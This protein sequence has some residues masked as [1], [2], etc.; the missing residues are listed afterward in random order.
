MDAVSR[1]SN[2]RKSVWGEATV[3]LD[4]VVFSFLGMGAGFTE[5][6]AA[7]VVGGQAG[8]LEDSEAGAPGNGFLTIGA[9]EIG[10]EADSVAR[11]GGFTLSIAFAP[12]GA[13]CCGLKGAKEGEGEG[14]VTR[15]PNPTATK[16]MSSRNQV[17]ELTAASGRPFRVLPS[18]NLSLPG[19]CMSLRRGRIHLRL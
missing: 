17:K 12:M 4:A 1:F 6:L 16:K 2:V 8:S 7:D 5:V 14:G 3:G 9:G 18:Q 15:D 19:H 10:E 13:N 11:A